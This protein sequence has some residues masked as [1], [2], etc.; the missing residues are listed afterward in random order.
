[1]RVKATISVCGIF[2]LM[3]VLLAGGAGYASN[4][5]ARDSSKTDFFFDN[6]PEKIIQS[7]VDWPGTKKANVI[8]NWAE[9]TF[10]DVFSPPTDSVDMAGWYYR[11]YWHTD[12][13]LG[14][15][16]DMLYFL[17][18][19]E[20]LHDL[21]MVNTW[22]TWLIP[23]VKGLVYTFNGT[24]TAGQVEFHSMA[25]ERVS[26]VVSNLNAAGLFDITP[27]EPLPDYVMVTVRD[28]NT[29]GRSGMAFREEAGGM[30][31]VPDELQVL[32]DRNQ[33]HQTLTRITP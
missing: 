24:V 13:W 3:F 4:I 14:T 32:I 23:T 9:I 6:R 26:D 27:Q 7:Q 11:H 2:F 30:F 17:D 12:T 16:G 18:Q 29:M 10:P 21:G 25:G 22:L 15:Y 31:P 28:I 5:P 8:F 33:A 1:M 19:N 20:M